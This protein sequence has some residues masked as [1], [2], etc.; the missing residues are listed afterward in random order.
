MVV[1]GATPGYRL[2]RVPMAAF[3]SF[4]GHR[5][6][7]YAELMA[8]CKGLELTIH[9]KH[10]VLEVEFDLITV[11]SFIFSSGPVYYE[12]AHVLSKVHALVSSSII[13]VRHVLCKVTSA[14][15]SWPIRLVLIE[16]VGSSCM[17]RNFQQGCMVFFIWST[18]SSPY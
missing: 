12:Y 2:Q 4:L 10:R 1:L 8:V 16:L 6:I 3:G 11:V 18:D 5:P 17:L 7:L 14:M 9:L 15:F 13:L